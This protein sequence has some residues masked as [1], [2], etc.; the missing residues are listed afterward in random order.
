MKVKCVKSSWDSVTLSEQG[1]AYYDY[2]YRIGKSGSVRPAVIGYESFVYAIV[3]RGGF[4]SYFIRDP[5]HG[6]MYHC[7]E[8]C[9]EVTDPRLSKY[10]H[11]QHRY[12]KS[13]GLKMLGETYPT[14]WLGFPELLNEPMFLENY[15]EGNRREVSIFESAASL[16]ENEY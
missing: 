14:T 7:P 12:I 15:I 10:W 5:K 3:A 13:Q 6:D 11:F 1:R 4:V 9:F 2:I 8:F 16:I